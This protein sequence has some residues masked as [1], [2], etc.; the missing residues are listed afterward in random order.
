MKHIS[1]TEYLN[2]EDQK[3]SKRKGIGV[4]GGDVANIPIQIDSWRFYLLSIRPEGSDTQFKWSDFKQ[5]VNNELLGNLGNF[6]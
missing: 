6:C 4:F 2:Y 3:F 1:T 5:K